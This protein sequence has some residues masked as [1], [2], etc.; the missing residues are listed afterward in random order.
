MHDS[1]RPVY[2]LLIPDVGAP[3]ETGFDKIR[4]FL[5]RVQ[6]IANALIPT[7]CGELSWMINVQAVGKLVESVF[8]GDADSPDSGLI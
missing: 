4:G 8:G 2:A 5:S 1:D 7:R 6:E 3:P